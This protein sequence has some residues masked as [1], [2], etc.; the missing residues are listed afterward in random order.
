MPSLSSIGLCLGSI[1]AEIRPIPREHKRIHAPLAEAADHASLSK[2]RS[3]RYANQRWAVGAVASLRARRVVSG[4]RLVA[5]SKAYFVEHGV[6]PTP[7]ELGRHQAVVHAMRSGGDSWTFGH[8]DGTEAAVT[9]S[10]GVRASSRPCKTSSHPRP[11]PRQES[12]HATL[13][14]NVGPT[15]F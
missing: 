13:R 2:A 5:G 1:M 14:Q 11:G 12:A 7:A 3:V 4:R 9:V 6:R 10:G 15:T 8:T